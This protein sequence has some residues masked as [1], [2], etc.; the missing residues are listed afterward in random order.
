MIVTK[1]NK[2]RNN[3]NLYYLEI[4][5]EFCCKTKSTLISDLNIFLGKEINTKE[6]NVIVDATNYQECLNKSFALL[7]I[8]MNSKKEL[9]KKLERGFDYKTVGKVINRLIELNY[10]NDETFANSWIDARSNCKGTYMLRRELMKKGIDNKTIDISLGRL[11]PNDEFHCAK[12]LVEKKQWTVTTHEEK[13]K[14]IF[15][16]LARKGFD[17]DIIKKV[18]NNDPDI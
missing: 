12:K 4:D 7:A 14:K 17:Y 1:L 5:N 8:R 6:F 15:A 3:D 2:D 13:N 16:F 10:V 18:T 11:D 9:E